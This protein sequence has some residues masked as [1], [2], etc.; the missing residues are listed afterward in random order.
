MVAVLIAH[1]YMIEEDD[2][3]LEDFGSST[4]SCRSISSA[5]SVSSLVVWDSSLVVYT[6]LLVCLKSFR[7][8]LFSSVDCLEYGTL[9]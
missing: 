6:L 8:C 7:N 1:F 3:A 4:S 5:L 9:R 2:V